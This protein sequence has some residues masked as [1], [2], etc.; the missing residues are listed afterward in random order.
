LRN[1]VARIRAFAPVFSEKEKPK[2][3]TNCAGFSIPRFR[4]IKTRSA[5]NARASPQ[6]M[7]ASGLTSGGNDMATV[8]KKSSA[9]FESGPG[10]RAGYI[11]AGGARVAKRTKTHW[12]SCRAG[13]SVLMQASG[14][15]VQYRGN[16]PLKVY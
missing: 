13:W 2:K 16:P 14:I 4:K 6:Q 3:K 11:T 12:V 8:R 5:I 15:Y 10:G 7:A 1:D 9:R